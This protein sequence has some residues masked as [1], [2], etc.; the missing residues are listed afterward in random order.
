MRALFFG[1][2]LLGAC[3][4]TPELSSGE[5]HVP[6]AVDGVGGARI[7]LDSTERRIVMLGGCSGHYVDYRL[8][9]P[10]LDVVEE[11]VTT[12]ACFSGGP[13]ADDVNSRLGEL[14]NRQPRVVPTDR[15]FDLIPTDGARVSFVQASKNAQN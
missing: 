5:Y 7:R 10:R 1:L 11:A 12:E 4:P 2:F 15:G 13:Y 6:E 14:L 8:D 9:G 3:T